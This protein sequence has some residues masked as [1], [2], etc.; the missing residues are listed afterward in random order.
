M[1]PKKTRGA[2]SFDVTA[3]ECPRCHDLFMIP[4]TD[5]NGDIMNT[6]CPEC[7]PNAR[8]GARPGA[9]RP[10]RAVPLT[11]LTVRL[12]PEDAARFK[13]VCIAAGKTHAQW[14]ADKIRRAKIK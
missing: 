1:T 10:R 5:P 11:V 7:A 13:E 4:S 9:G 14:L 8:G 6:P 12:E 2:S 3:D